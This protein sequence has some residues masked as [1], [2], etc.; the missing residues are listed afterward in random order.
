MKIKANNKLIRFVSILMFVILFTFMLFPNHYAT[1]TYNIIELGFKEA[2][3][4]MTVNEFQTYIEDVV[5]DI[6]SYKEAL[7]CLL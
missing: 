3:I 6:N 4:K 7:K 5:K 1:D 2:G